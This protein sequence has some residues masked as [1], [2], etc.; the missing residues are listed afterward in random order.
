MNRDLRQLELSTI[1]SLRIAIEHLDSDHTVVRENMHTAHEL[2]LEHLI[3]WSDAFGTL[4]NHLLEVY[5]AHTPKP[6]GKYR[7]NYIGVGYSSFCVQTWIADKE[8]PPLPTVEE[9]VAHF[10]R[11]VNEY[12]RSEYVAE[13]FTLNTSTNHSR[14]AE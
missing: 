5:R 1:A 10:D 2:F 7:V 8:Q 9:L 4:Y 3:E 12:L 13:S 6:Q 14:G 11:F